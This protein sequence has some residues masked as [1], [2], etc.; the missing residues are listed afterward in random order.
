M[1]KNPEANIETIRDAISKQVEGV[2][3]LNL[4]L[5]LKD[6]DIV[7]NRPKGILNLY[8]RAVDWGEN[9]KVLGKILLNPF[10]MGAAAT[11]ATQGVQRAI[12]WA[13][14]GGAVAA[15]ATGFWVP[16]GIGAAVGGIYRGIKPGK[17][18]KY[19]LTQEERQETLGGKGS[20]ILDAKKG[21]VFDKN[22][23]R[24][25]G[26]AM[27]YK[28]AMAQITAMADKKTFTEEEQQQLAKIYARLQRET[29]T[30]RDTKNKFAKLDM[31]SMDEDSGKRFGSPMAAKSDLKIALKNLAINEQE[32]QSRI[33]I[34]KSAITAIVKQT[35]KKRAVFKAVEQTKSFFGGAVMGF[36]GG[37]LLEAMHLGGEQAEKLLG[38]QLF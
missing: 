25:D 33:D 28:D 21:W 30:L 22:N 19:D 12:K 26:A 15:G 35:D 24:Y 14:V 6:R 38:R 8:E 16:L 31:F 32:L 34:E 23:L 27:T 18:V 5:G 13:A 2:R 37:I 20:D 7:N 11:V 4:Q 3:G 9:H 1:D 10:V 36:A 29:D 17:V